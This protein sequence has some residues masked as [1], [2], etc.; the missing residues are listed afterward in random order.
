MIFPLRERI[1]SPVGA[2]AKGEVATFPWVR[3][4]MLI[5]NILLQ[6][7]TCQTGDIN[8][9][10]AMFTYNGHFNLFMPFAI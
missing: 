8:A 2:R 7:V 1:G 3:G 9:S 5:S 10:M 4:R 6:F